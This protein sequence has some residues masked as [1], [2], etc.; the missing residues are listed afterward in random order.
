M[1]DRG[2]SGDAAAPIYELG[3]ATERVSAAAEAAHAA[4]PGMVL[5][6]RAENFLH[7]APDLDDTVARLVAYR[8]A[9]ADV[10]YA[11][12]LRGIDDVRRV[13]DAV[14]APVNVLL[15]PNLPDVVELAS[16]GVARI[17]VGSA[18]H[19]VTLA[20]LSGAARELLDGGGGAFLELAAEGRA[21]VAR[22]FASGS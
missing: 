18:F 20:A 7:G 16:A 8:D 4:E 14:A 2:L 9:G 22:A 21:L 5:T 11:P 3:E 12:G 1:F 13:V 17:S 10:L 6:A 19:Q 15:R